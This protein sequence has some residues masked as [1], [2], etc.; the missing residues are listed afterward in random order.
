M[1]REVIDCDR[2]KAKEKGTVTLYFDVG[3]R[4][5]AAGG[6]SELISERL[7]L[8]QTCASI[9][10]ESLLSPLGND[11]RKSLWLTFGGQP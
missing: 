8:C 3:T 2:C 6:P 11:R 7:D 9:L 5:D 10:I 4:P 1:R